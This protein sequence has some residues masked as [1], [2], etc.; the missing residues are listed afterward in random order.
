MPERKSAM[1][2]MIAPCLFGLE[3]VLSF[4]L[5]KLGFANVRAEN[6][7]VRFDAEITDIP[8]ANIG[9]RTAERVLICLGEFEARSFEELFQNVKK[10]PWQDFIGVKDKF[11]V[12]GYSLNSQLHS[13]PDCQAIIKKAVVEKLKSIYHID[14][15]EETGNLYQI[16]F[17]IRKD[18]VCIMLDTSGQG[19]HKRGYRHDASEAPI[20]ETI[21]AGL[22]DVARYKGQVPFCDP[23]CGSGTL[24]IEAAMRVKNMAPGLYRRFVS[25]EWGQIDRKVWGDTRS[26]FLSA[27]VRP[28]VHLYGSDIDPDVI[29]VARSNAKKAKVDD[30]VSFSVADVKNFRGAEGATVVTNPP[31]GERLLDIREA[32]DV[33]TAMGRTIYG[34]GRKCYII[35]PDEE[36]ETF[37]GHKAD[38]KRKIYNGMI[39]CDF[40]EYFR[41]KEI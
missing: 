25:E 13:V 27:T 18:R 14:W 5:T 29:E 23:L 16:Q 24:V 6:G 1:L 12:K 26:E 11:P 15:F 34:Q 21:A 9:L 36:F 7:R 20:K 32:R 41:T 10:L 22:I 33:Y 28:D 37:F 35:S 19:L 30:I 2:E 4:E 31:Y 8:K 3:S 39:R 40:F 17:S 38:K